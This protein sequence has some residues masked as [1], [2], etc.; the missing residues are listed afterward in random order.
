ML[1]VL[2]VLVILVIGSLRCPFLVRLLT[3]PR[4]SKGIQS[5]CLYFLISTSSLKNE[6]RVSNFQRLLEGELAVTLQSRNLDYASELHFPVDWFPSLYVRLIPLVRLAAHAG[7]ALPLG[8]GLLQFVCILM[9]YY[10]DVYLV[11]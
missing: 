7:F 8:D 3:C 10:V 5:A 6:S 11:A 2:P 1:G 9:Y 4:N